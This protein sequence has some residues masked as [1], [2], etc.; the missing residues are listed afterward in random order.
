MGAIERLTVTLPADMAGLVKDAV[1]EGDYSSTSEV[2][3]EALLDWKLKRE[4]RLNKLAALKAET[5]N[6]MADVKAGKVSKFNLNEIASL[7]KKL[8][9]DPM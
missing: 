3:R 6:G 7:A 2:I 8:R 4:L 9:A 1:D 5:E